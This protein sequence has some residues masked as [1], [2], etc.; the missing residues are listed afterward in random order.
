MQEGIMSYLH[1]CCWLWRVQWMLMLHLHQLC[2]QRGWQIPKWRGRRTWF[3]WLC[4]GII[5]KKKKSAW[6]IK[7]AKKK[8]KMHTDCEDF[9]KSRNTLPWTLSVCHLNQ[10]T[11][12]HRPAGSLPQ[13]LFFFFIN[14]FVFAQNAFALQLVQMN[15]LQKIP[16]QLYLIHN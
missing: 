10:L 5:M 16:S 6:K 1:P 3:P 12:C 4:S 8:K 7:L 2:T 14:S 13:N 15:W 11:W 9:T